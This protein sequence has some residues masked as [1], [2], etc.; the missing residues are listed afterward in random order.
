MYTIFLLLLVASLSVPIIESLEWDSKSSKKVIISL[1][2]FLCVLFMTCNVKLPT[3]TQYISFQSNT[4]DDCD[5]GRNM[6]FLLI[7]KNVSWDM[8][9]YD[10][11]LII[12]DN[13]R[14]K[15]D[16]NKLKIDYKNMRWIDGAEQK[17]NRS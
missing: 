4:Y 16:R 3:R 17:I 5:L 9:K 10:L 1:I 12:D 6:Q 13:T 8:D 15:L 14:I 7:R 11:F 2:V